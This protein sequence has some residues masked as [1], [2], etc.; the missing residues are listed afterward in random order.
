MQIATRTRRAGFGKALPFEELK[1]RSR[2]NDAARG[3][4]HDEEFSAVI[5]A[6]VPGYE[7][8]ASAATRVQSTT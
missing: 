2:I 4:D 5:R 8:A 7:S 3:H 6:G 1:R